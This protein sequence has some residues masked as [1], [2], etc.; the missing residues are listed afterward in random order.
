M[1]FIDK[2]RI[3]VKAGDG[4]A[5]CSAFRR[6]KYVPHGGPS[7]GDGGQGGDVI[8]VVDSSQRTLLDFQYQR[9]FKAE[10]GVHGQ[11][12]TK[13]G[14]NGAGLVVKVPPGT[15]IR[16]AGTGEFL[17][18]LVDEGQRLVVARGGRGGRG[19]ARF[20]TSTNQ[21]PTMAEKG[22]PGEERWIELELK[23]LADIGLVGFPNAGKSSLLARV[24]AAKPKVADYPFTTLSPNLGVVQAPDGRSFVLADIPGLIE[25][26]HEG[27]GLGHDFL[28]HIERCRLLIHVIDLSAADGREPI[29][30]FEAINHELNL[31]NPELAGRP[32]MV[33]LNKIDLPEARERLEQTVEE[34]RARGYP[35]YT[36]SAATG[37]GVDQL[38]FAAADFLVRL[39][40]PVLTEVQAAER[41][42]R[43]AVPSTVEIGREGDAYVVRGRD[44]ERLA[45]M[46][47]WDNEEAVR[48][49]QHIIRRR[50]IEERLRSL[51]ARDG[52][53]I[54][55]RDV[56][57]VLG[58]Y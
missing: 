9:H 27:V 4:G 53:I 49:F 42:Y 34:L 5:G 31:Y 17:G 44:I 12:S 47:D 48:R 8:L 24:S 13:H 1:V 20:A 32:Q 7:G 2:A 56:E 22:E 51:G 50:G 58:E 18:D 35:V 26:A 10:R 39:P 54:R 28:K 41:V 43:P 25:G 36:I 52:D 19:N 16:D 38:V 30:G 23:L 11:G 55:I 57:L 21:A 40:V 45:V 15:V 37:E 14:A 46:T 29:E 3:N 33:A 6:E